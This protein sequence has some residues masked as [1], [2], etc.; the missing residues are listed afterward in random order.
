MTGREIAQYI[1]KIFS[2]GKT[3]GLGKSGIGANC[4]EDFDP[5]GIEYWTWKDGVII[6]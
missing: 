1:N 5:R 3:L 6:Q 2:S 4:E